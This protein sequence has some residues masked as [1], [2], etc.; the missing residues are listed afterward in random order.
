[1]LITEFLGQY[2]IFVSLCFRKLSHIFPETECI[3][4]NID[5]NRERWKSLKNS[6]NNNHNLLVKNYKNANT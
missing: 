5:D 4:G 2:K 3:L 1:M 6:H